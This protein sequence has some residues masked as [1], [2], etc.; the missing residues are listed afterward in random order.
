MPILH[1]VRSSFRSEWRDRYL[2][3]PKLFD[4]FITFLIGLIVNHENSMGS[5]VV[6]TGDSSE[7][8]L[9]RRIPNLQFNYVP[10]DCDGSRVMRIILKS[11][12]HSERGQICLLKCVVCKSPK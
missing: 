7:M 1:L 3:E 9:S 5:P 2:F 10:V 11:E 6:G 8:F 4:I 12:V